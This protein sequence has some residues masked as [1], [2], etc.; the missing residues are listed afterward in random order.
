MRHALT[1]AQLRLAR[2]LRQ[3]NAHL[4]RLPVTGVTFSDR[5]AEQAWGKG[6]RMDTV[7]ALVEAGVLNATPPDRCGRCEFRLTVAT[8][9]AA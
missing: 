5:Q 3:H 6:V 4:I 9:A 7:T 1:P 2:I 8:H